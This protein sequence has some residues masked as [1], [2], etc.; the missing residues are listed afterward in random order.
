MGFYR[1][2][3]ERDSAPVDGFYHGKLGSLYILHT[4]GIPVIC[5]FRTPWLAS[6][7]VCAI[8]K[9]CHCYIDAM[10]QVFTSTQCGNRAGQLAALVAYQGEKVDVADA[11]KFQDLG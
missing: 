4:P 1:D 10:R 11:S 6:I 3:V 9:M 7:Q 5:A 8:H 2:D